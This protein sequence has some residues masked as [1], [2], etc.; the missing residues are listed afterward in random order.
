MAPEIWAMKRA[1][2]VSDRTRK[3]AIVPVLPANVNAALFTLWL[4]RLLKERQLK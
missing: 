1:L 4:V 3:F 2:C